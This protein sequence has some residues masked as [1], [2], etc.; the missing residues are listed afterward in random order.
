MQAE[1]GDVGQNDSTNNDGTN[2]TWHIIGVEELRE[3]VVQIF[4]RFGK[5][6]HVLAKDSEKWDGTYNGKKLPNNDYWFVLSFIDE[7]GFQQQVK[8][9]FSLLY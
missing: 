6:L 1:S 4:D 5:V 3:P 9:H 8:S 7:N 2:D